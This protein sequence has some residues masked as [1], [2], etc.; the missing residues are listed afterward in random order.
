MRVMNP[1]RRL[2]LRGTRGGQHAWLAA[3]A[4]LLARA[5]LPGGVM[6]DPVSAAAGDFALVVCS[7][8]GPMF[9]HGHGVE[10]DSTDASAGM[11]MNHMAGM[12]HD[13]GDMLD[14][15][16]HDYLSADDGLCP[17]SAALVV[18]CVGVALAI[19]LF[20]LARVTRSWVAVSARALVRPSPCS[21]PP[22][23]APPLFG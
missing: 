13:A 6:L 15:P 8:H 21:L 11:D 20:A 19:V 10:T 22:P 1:F 4:L 7:G 12:M 23:R 16:A 2:L 5:L 17:F 14:S 3:L 18:A 9:A